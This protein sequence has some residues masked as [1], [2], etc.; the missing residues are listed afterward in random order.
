MLHTRDIIQQIW[1]AQGYG[2]LAVWAEGATEVI[3]PG[4]A[5]EKG[6]E[7]PLAVFKPIPLV[8]GFPMVDNALYNKDLLEEIETTIREAGG[9]IE[10]D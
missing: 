8:G 3:A 1:D 5:P 7:P 10:R 9:E 2:N 4:S 6:G